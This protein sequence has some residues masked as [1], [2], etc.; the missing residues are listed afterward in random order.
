[1]ALIFPITPDGLG[2]DVLVN[3]EA[4]ILVRLWQQ[5][6]QPAPAQGRGIIDTGSDLVLCRY[7]SCNILGFH[8]SS[9]LQLR[10]SVDLYV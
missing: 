5:G 8:Q 3:L 9:K 6:V 1:M 10:G 2:V 7:P 4:A